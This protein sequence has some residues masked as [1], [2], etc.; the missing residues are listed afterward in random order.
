M[1]RRALAILLLVLVLGLA[2]GNVALAQSK[3]LYWQRYDVDIAI[4]TNGDFRVTETQEL[5]F[6]SGTFHFGQREINLNRLNNISDV[7]VKEA[8]GP[9]YTQC[10]Q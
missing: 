3:S 9:R 10:R 8:N 1:Q 5:V 6:T 2:F 7:T 4:Q